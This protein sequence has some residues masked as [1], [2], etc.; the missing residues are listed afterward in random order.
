MQ[1][2][3]GNILKV[4]VRH[5]YIR[6]GVFYYQRAVPKE[7]E[8]KYGGKLIKLNLGIPASDPVAAA[9]K[10]KELNHRYE[11]EWALLKADPAAV[12]RAAQVQ[13]LKLLES[14]G[15]DPN[16]PD[17][18]EAALDHFLARLDA[19]R[20]VHAGGAESRYRDAEPSDFLL[21]AEAAA[22]ALLKNPGKDRLSDALT[23]YLQ[24]HAKGNDER[25]RKSSSIAM[26][27]LIAAVGDK[28][29]QDLTRAEGRAYI[30]AEL[31]RGIATTTVRRYLRSLVAILNAY[32]REREI[33]CPK[34]LEG[35]SI[36]GEGE[37]AK[38]RV[39]FTKNELHKLQEKCA[40]ADDDLR[41]ILAI[42]ADTGARLAEVVGLALDDLRLDCETPHIAIESRPWRSIKRA[43]GK[44]D[45]SRREVP[46]VGSALWAVQRIKEATKGGQVVAFPRYVKDGQCNA[47]TASATLNGWLRSVGIPHTCHELRHTMRDRLR[48]VQCPPDIAHAIGGW[49]H[50]DGSL[51]HAYGSGYSLTV[52]AQWLRRV[53]VT[54]AAQ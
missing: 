8:G 42:L 12:P 32:Y 21:P 53:V 17:N 1:I 48:E 43:P 45:W 5:T 36:R 49:S 7:F 26:D 14:A 19:K 51:G 50:K 22:V 52:K 34:P 46:L 40:V 23:L 3:I 11:K 25:L 10:V 6:K 9:K 47:E 18:D 41:W 44:P 37:D 31:A 16:A 54:V 38:K 20:E 2:T 15:I 13:G 27:G 33:T 28:P 30:E 29:V 35:L 39:P 24:T 4:S